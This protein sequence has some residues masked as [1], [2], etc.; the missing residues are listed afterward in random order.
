VRAFF[1]KHQDRI[2]FGSDFIV[3]GVGDMQLGSVS[4][5]APTVDDAVEFFTRHW[6]YFETDAVQ[7]DH[8]TPIQGPWKVDAINLPA[9]V[10]KKIYVT[11]AERLIWASPL[12]GA[13]A[14]IAS[15]K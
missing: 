2:L 14:P 12:P 1:V 15:P 6:K 11:N 8:P 4:H 5:T 7:M 3:D 10:L 9:E 13:K